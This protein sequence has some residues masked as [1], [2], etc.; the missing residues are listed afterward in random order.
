MNNWK[1]KSS[2]D[3]LEVF[4]KISSHSS[5]DVDAPTWTPR[6]KKIKE[7]LDESNIAYEIIHYKVP[8]YNRD[9]TNIYISFS[10]DLNIPGLIFLAHHDIANKDSENCQDNTASISHLLKLALDLN[11]NP[12]PIPIHIAIVDSE[13]H[14]NLYCCGSQVL[15]EDINC[16]KF[17]DISACI[18]LELTGLGKHIWV[19]SFE[20]FEDICDP[21]IELFNANKVQTP[22][23]DALVL[24]LHGIPAMCI[25][26][27]DDYDIDVALNGY[28]YPNIWGLCHRMEDTF[29]KISKEDMDELYFKLLSICN[30]E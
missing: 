22:Y 23:N 2:Y 16:G 13:E 8:V 28:G 27:L 18:N 3:I 11:D 7:F 4:S 6:L 5:F 30:Y 10:K 12:P 9:F 1:I 15:S 24:S 25:G 26:I 20:K 14:V 29:D 19:S 17:G 21:Y